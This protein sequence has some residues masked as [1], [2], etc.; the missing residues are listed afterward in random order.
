KASLLLL[1]PKIDPF[2][3]TRITNPQYELWHDKKPS[4]TFLRVFGALCCPTNDS[5]DLRKLQP[6]ADIG[7]F[8]GYAPSRKDPSS[9][10]D[11]WS[12]FVSRLVPN[13]VHAA[14]YVPPTN[15]ELEI[16]FQLM[17]D[18]YLDPPHVER[19][20]SSA[21]AVQVLVISAGIPSST[22]ID[23]D[24][25]SPSHS[26]SCLELQPHISHQGVAVGSTIIEDNPFAHVD[27]DPFVNVFAPEPSSK[28]SSSRDVSS[29]EST[30]VTQ[31][32]H[33]LRK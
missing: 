11:A 17:F 14:P 20:V 1:H 16:L 30:H 19:P 32:H 4:L 7:I 33:H 18:E 12:E 6:T 8:V 28:A 25:P 21:I 24:A 27:N 15:K 5:E 29:A 9:F 31:P 13:L 23:Q 22:T 3:H 10:Y 2:I 26:L